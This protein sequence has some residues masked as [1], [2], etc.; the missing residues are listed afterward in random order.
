MKSDV[1]SRKIGETE[2]E[3]IDKHIEIY[4]CL[5]KNSLFC[6]YFDKNFV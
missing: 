5:N 1:K 3:I 4:F 6:D 2:T